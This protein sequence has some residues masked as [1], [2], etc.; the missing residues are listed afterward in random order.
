[1]M[2][3]CSLETEPWWALAITDVG[4]GARPGLGHD[5]GRL[6]AG[7]LQVAA[8]P[9]GGD[10]VEPRGQALGEAAG[11]GE[12]D[13]RAVLLDEVDDVLLD[14]RPDRAAAAVVGVG[15]RVEVSAVGCGHVLD[16]D[17]DLEVP[18]LVG[19]RRDDLDRRVAAEEAG[20][21]VEGAHGR[22]EADALRGL[23]EERVEPLEAD[24]QVGAALASGDG[25]HLV[26]DDGVDPAEGLARLRGQHEEQRLGRG[27]E[28][29]G[30]L[31][32]QPAPFLGGGVAGP[33]ADAHLGQPGCAAGDNRSAVWRMPASGA[34]RLRSTSTP[35][36][37]SGEM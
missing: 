8:G 5:L 36:A 7:L 9:G 4:S 14:V 26:D 19:G 3:R 23:V 32:G 35:R 28:D 1:M 24:C 20:H 17:D 31:A 33:D 37:F 25:V 21:L 16:G 27:D 34:R 10:L 13:G 6:L 11:V 22:G 30:R 2:A 15:I 12:H 29:V 18:G